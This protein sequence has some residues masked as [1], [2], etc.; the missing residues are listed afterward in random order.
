M[1]VVRKEVDVDEVLRVDLLDA[2]G[3]LRQRVEIA[4]RWLVPQEVSAERRVIHEPPDGRLRVGLKLGTTDQQLDARRLRGV[5]GPGHVRRIRK[6]SKAV[7]ESA[8]SQFAKS[9]DRR[10]RRR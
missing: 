1:G 4:G 6:P 10:L 8:L 5:Q 7:S 2:P 3:P 9:I